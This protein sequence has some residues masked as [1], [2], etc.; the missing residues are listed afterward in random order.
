MFEGLL[1]PTHLLLILAI[2]LIVVGPGK[3]GDLGG[4]LGKSVRD[5][6]HMAEGTGPTGGASAPTD[7]APMGQL[8]AG[9]SRFCTGC[10]A[11]LAATASFCSAC[12][13]KSAA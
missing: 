12:G 4:Q 11:G 13:A 9:G 6:R 8:T 1:Q 3:I 5:F 7:G 2:A 10:G